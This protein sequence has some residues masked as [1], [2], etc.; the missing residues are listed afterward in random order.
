MGLKLS[1]FLLYR[2]RFLK[3]RGIFKIAIFEHEIWTMAKVPEVAHACILSFYPSGSKLSLFLNPR[4][5]VAGVYPNI[6]IFGYETWPLAKVPETVHI[7]PKLLLSPKYHSVLLYRWP[8]PTDLQFCIFPL[9]TMLNFNPFLKS[10]IFETS[11]K[12]L[13]CGL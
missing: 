2:Q 3:H 13:L 4:A 9:G 8:F 11:K 7:L 12:Q 1:L 5:A 6:A 10:L